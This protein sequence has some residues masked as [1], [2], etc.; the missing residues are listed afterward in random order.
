MTKLECKSCG[1]EWEYGGASDYYASC[2][3]CLAKV[4]VKKAEAL[5]E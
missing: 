3:R 1:Y 2:P 5:K 4:R